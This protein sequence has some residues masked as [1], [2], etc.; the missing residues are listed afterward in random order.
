MPRRP[1]GCPS[2]LSLD[3]LEAGDLAEAEVE[4]AEAADRGD[5]RDDDGD[6]EHDRQPRSQASTTAGHDLRR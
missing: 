2:T 3:E 6:V 5:E 1:A 4:D